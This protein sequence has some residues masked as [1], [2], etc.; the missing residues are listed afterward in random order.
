MDVQQFFDDLALIPNWRSAQ[1]N[2]LTVSDLDDGGFRFEGHAAVFGDI[3]DLGEFTESIERGAF[4]KVL[5]SAPNIP[6]LVE[7]DPTKLLATTRAQTLRLAEDTKGLR[8]E[9]DVADTS[10][11]R[12]V[13]A[14]VKRGDLYGMSFGF[15]SGRG[16]HKVSRR[17]GKIHRSL[18]GFKKILDVCATWDP[19]YRNA[20]AQFRSLTMRYADSPGK[21]QQLLMGAYPQLEAQGSEPVDREEEEA[22]AELVPAP[23]EEQVNEVGEGE[24]SRAA[25]EPSLSA[26]A[27]RNRLLVMSLDLGKR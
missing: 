17:D 13:R 26:A 11:G 24:A 27:A 8:V 25:E 22:P 10:L 16:N 9:A 15:V 4:R 23:D 2:D 12:D 3:T 19:A 6:L 14:L 21:L 5:T 1:F 20:E 18:T 7:H